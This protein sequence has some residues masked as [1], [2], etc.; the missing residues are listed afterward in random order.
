MAPHDDPPIDGLCDAHFAAVRDAFA[1]NLTTRGDVGAA[2]AVWVGVRPVVDLLGG[3]A[4]AARSRPWQRDTL[5]NFFSV[6]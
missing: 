6:G 5:V 1:T 2:V 3:W 4:C